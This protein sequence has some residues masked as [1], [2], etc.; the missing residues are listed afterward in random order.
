VDAGRRPGPLL[1]FQSVPNA[2]AGYVAARHDLR[3]PVLCLAPA[4]DGLVT[5]L[6]A[7]S[8]LV[9]DGDADHA[10]VVLV[11]QDS[12]DPSRGHALALLVSSARNDLGGSP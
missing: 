1:F 3:G 7:V 8:L 6:D 11:E 5:G 4:K 10:L 2:V 9:A 12:A